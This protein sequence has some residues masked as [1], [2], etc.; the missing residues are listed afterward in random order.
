MPFVSRIAGVPCCVHV[1]Y[2]V[3]SEVKGMKGIILE[4]I[5]QCT[6]VQGY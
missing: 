3:S 1:V 5:L 2:E 6:V 4:R